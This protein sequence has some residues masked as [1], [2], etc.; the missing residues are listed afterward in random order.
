MIGESNCALV[1]TDRIVHSAGMKDGELHLTTGRARG[2]MAKFFPPPK[3]NKL[4]ACEQVA[5]IC[6]RIRSS[7]IEFLLIRTRGGRWTFPK[8]GIEPGLTYAQAA[9]LEAFE[10][11]GVHG[12]MEDDS[13]THYIRRK[14]TDLRSS[15]GSGDKI[16]VN[17]HLCEVLRLGPPQ[18]SNRN[19]TW[20]SVQKAKHRLQ[21]DR[22]SDNG[23][24]LA[25]VV[26]LAVAR[27]QRFHSANRTMDGPQKDA[28]QK[29]Q[30]EAVEAAGRSGR[31][32]TP[33]FVQYIPGQ[34]RDMRP[35]A[36][37]KLAVNP[38]LGKV[39]QLAPAREVNQNPAT[40]SAENAK[41]GLENT[42]NSRKRPL[43]PTL[44]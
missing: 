4:R 2:R 33:S 43:D 14:R 35:S 7:G 18:E 3:S 23:A 31:M 44:E 27:I 16:I 37:I 15:A 21:Q 9:A 17:A 6:Y 19:P 34:R 11:A 13:F 26:D 36:A 38:N 41:R 22:K 25:R 39:L 20:F 30:F 12:R 29:V 42:F 8:G 10:E 32:A 1:E 24:Q 28:L 5:A 40:F